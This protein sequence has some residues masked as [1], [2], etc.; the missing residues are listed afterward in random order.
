MYVYKDQ[1]GNLVISRNRFDLRRKGM[2][3]IYLGKTKGPDDVIVIREIFSDHAENRFSCKDRLS[4]DAGNAV[5]ALR[6]LGT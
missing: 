4:M 3:Y 2:N 6:P 1:N 5:F